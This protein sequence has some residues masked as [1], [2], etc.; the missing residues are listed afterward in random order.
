MNYAHIF[1]QYESRATHFLNIYFLF[2]YI[3]S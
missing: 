1:M 2:F 3:I